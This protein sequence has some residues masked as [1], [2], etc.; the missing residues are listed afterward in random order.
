M[1]LAAGVA[2]VIGNVVYL[3][4]GWIREGGEYLADLPGLFVLT[5]VGTAPFLFLGACAVWTER[6]LGLISVTI[7]SLIVVATNVYGYW[8]VFFPGEDSTSTDGLVFVFIV[9]VQW[10]VAAV[11]G[12]IVSARGNRQPVTR[13]AA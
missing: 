2:P 7:A 6:T 11:A 13:V 1:L 10:V 12:L 9:P 8:V 3:G 5:L 4:A